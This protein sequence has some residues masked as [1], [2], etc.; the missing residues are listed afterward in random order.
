MI[1]KRCQIERP[2]VSIL[3][4]WTKN[5]ISLQQHIFVWHI[6]RKE[7]YGFSV[8][9]LYPDCDYHQLGIM[10]VFMVLPWAIEKPTKASRTKK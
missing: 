4:K 6:S 9:E 3:G 8:F 1:G 10:P 7:F 2:R 5:E